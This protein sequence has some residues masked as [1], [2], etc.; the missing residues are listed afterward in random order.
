MVSN[1]SATTNLG[2]ENIA[3]H[4]IREFSL[5]ITSLDILL[6]TDYTSLLI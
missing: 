5:V 6:P 1:T 2:Q 3:L 4:T